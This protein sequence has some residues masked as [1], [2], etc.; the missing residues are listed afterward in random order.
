MNPQDEL[1]LWVGATRYYMGRMTYA[2]SNFC[3]LLISEWPNLGPLTRS[4][5]E[6]DLKDEIERDDRSRESGRTGTLGMDCDRAEWNNV[7]NEITKY[8]LLKRQAAEPE[9]EK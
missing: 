2:V 7:M 9:I 6:R 5:I 8:R 1:T 3:S 4:L